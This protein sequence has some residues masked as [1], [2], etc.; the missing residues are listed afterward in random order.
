MNIE[1]SVAEIGQRLGEWGRFPKYALERRVDIFLTPFLEEFFSRSPEPAQ[2]IKLVAPEFPILS[3]IR[4][5]AAVTGRTRQELLTSMHARTIN[6]DYLLYRAGPPPAWVFVELKTEDRSFSGEQFRRYRA[7]QEVGMDELVGHIELRLLGR[8][9]SD[10]HEKYQLLLST[11]RSVKAAPRARIE[12]VY[13]APKCP[14]EID[15]A[16][17]YSRNPKEPRFHSLDA[18]LSGRTSHPDLQALVKRL[19]AALKLKD[20]ASAE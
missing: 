4:E 8:P 9:G 16:A 3:R 18:Y 14:K 11:I 5:L 1:R 10:F 13:L 12:I 20:S 19:L 15:P 2:T 7:A 17:T 6:V